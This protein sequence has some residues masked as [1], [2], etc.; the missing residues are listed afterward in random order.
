MLGLGGVFDWVLV[1]LWWILIGVVGGF[2]LVF[3]GWFLFGFI[4]FGGF[5]VASFWLVFGELQ[6]GFEWLSVRFWLVFGC[7]LLALGCLKLSGQAPPKRKWPQTFNM[8]L[9]FK[10][11]R[12]D[13][14]NCSS[15]NSNRYRSK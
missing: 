8:K 2:E 11:C 15:N 14:D 7:F 10:S 1:G 6:V 3:G 5:E 4:V 9:F 13:I 12:L